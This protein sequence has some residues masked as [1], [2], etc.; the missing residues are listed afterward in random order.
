M[1]TALVLLYHNLCTVLL[2]ISL[3]C[4][5]LYCHRTACPLPLYCPGASKRLRTVNEDR[6]CAVLC[7]AV[8]YC[9]VLWCWMTKR[10]L[11]TAMLCCIGL[12]LYCLST[13]VVLLK[14][15]Q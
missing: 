7:C 5:V 2:C 13:L 12:M 9:A 8:R 11:T 14:H 6:P 3:Y 4:S 10:M 15:Y 1:C